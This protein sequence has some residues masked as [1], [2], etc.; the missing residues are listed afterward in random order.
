MYKPDAICRRERV[1]GEVAFS[2]RKMKGWEP[3]DEV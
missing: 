3:E 1:R 2:G